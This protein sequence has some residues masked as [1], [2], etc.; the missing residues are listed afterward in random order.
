MGRYVRQRL[1]P[2]IG[3]EGQRHLEA[4]RVASMRGPAG[5][6]RDLYLQRAGLTIDSDLTSTAPARPELTGDPALAVLVGAFEAV[7][8]IKR[9]LGVGVPGSLAGFACEDPSAPKGPLD[10][11]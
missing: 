11:R 2:E 1:L 4:T 7:E 9:V 3:D 6:V 8:E 10:V 5:A